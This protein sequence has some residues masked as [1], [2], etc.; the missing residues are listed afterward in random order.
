MR[1]YVHK[2]DT[3]EVIVYEEV[4]ITTPLG[5]LVEV[6]ADEL[7]FVA[8]VDGPIDPTTT[9]EAHVVA[10]VLF[11]HVMVHRCRRIDVGVNWNGVTKVE[12]LSPAAILEN[13][14]DWAVREFQIDHSEVPDLVF[15]MTATGPDL[16]FRDRVGSLTTPGACTIN[17]VL[18][19]G[20]KHAG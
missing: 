5:E 19:P 1:L 12:P 8:E 13:V 6:T 17:L 18:V 15:R 14:L 16:S 10:E 9:I 2:A 7:L 11:L 20:H 4:E 3:T